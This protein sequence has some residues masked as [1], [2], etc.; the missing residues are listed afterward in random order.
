MSADPLG[1]RSRPV[2]HPDETS[3]PT[4][5]TEPF[6][7]SA[8]GSVQ[9]KRGNL[10]GGAATEEALASSRKVLFAHRGSKDA[11]VGLQQWFAPP[12]AAA[13]IAAVFEHG[14]PPSAVFDPTAGSGSL[15]SGFP[16]ESR[17]GV[18]IDSDHATNAPYQ[19]ITA[20]AQKVVP[21]MRA[22]GLR[23]PAIALNPPFGLCW[24][25]AAHA[26]GEINSTVLAF[27]WAV[28]L[29]D[30][31]G[32]GAMICGTDRLATSVLGRPEA[33]GVYAVL[34]VEGPLFDGVDLATS[35]AF[36]VSP[37]NLRNRSTDHES[38]GP[39]RLKARRAD[40][41]EMA[42]AVAETRE[43]RC[44]FISSYSRIQAIAAGFS[45]VSSE[46]ARRQGEGREKGRSRFDLLLKGSKVSVNLRAFATLALREAGVLREV[47]LLNNQHS[48]YFGQNKRAW[49]TLVNAGEAGHITIDPAL[50]ERAEAAVAQAELQSIPLFPVKPQMRLGWL[51][52]LDKIRCKTD[53]PERGYTADEDYPLSTSSKVASET[54]RR[55]VENK[56]GDAEL[57]R[58]TTERK[59]LEVRIGE[60][61]FDEG[62][63]NIAYIAEHFELPDP[64]CVATHPDTDGEVLHHREL[65]EEIAAENG[66][67]LK[68]F[69]TDH[70]SR[71]LVKG[72]GMLAMEQGLGKTL[73]QMC[74]AE[75]QIRLGAKPQVLFVVPQDLIPQWQREARKFFGRELEEIRTPV[76][77]REAAR[78]IRAGESGWW[79]TYYEALSVVGR[80]KEVLPER[81]LDHRTALAE[82]LVER[83]KEKGLPAEV[84]WNLTEGRGTATTKDVCPECGAD[85]AYG[86]DTE[87]CRQCGYAHRSLHVKSAASH[88]SGAFEHG[89]V[90]VDEVS[91][92][93]GDD[94]LRSKAVRAL[95]RGP[96]RYGA[97]GTPVSN[98]ISDSFWGLLFCLGAASPAFPYSFE[99]KPKFET[100]F[101]VVEYLHGRA[102]DNEEH[103]KK[104]KKV[105]P[106]ITN[107]SQFWRLAQPGVSRCRKEQTGEPLAERTYHPVRAPMGA[108]QKKAHDFWLKN[109]ESYFAWRHPDHQLVKEGLVEK[110][111]AA[112]GQLW[113]LETAAPLP[114][115]DEPSREWPQARAKL[116][117]LSNFTPA[118]LKVLEL[119]MEH[120]E[121]GEKVLIGSDLIMTGRWLSD[122]LR[123]KGVRAVNITEERSGKVGTKNP[124][125]RSREVE[126]FV[127]GDAQVLCAGVGAMKLGHN[128]DVASTVI[129]SGLPYSFMALDQFLARVHRL[130]SRRAVSVYVVIPRGSL[131]ERKWQLLSDKGAASDLAFDGELTVAP[132]KPVDWAKVLEEMKQRGIR[133]SGDEDLVL[134]ADVKEAWS[135]VPVLRKPAA[136]SSFPDAAPHT[137]NNGAGEPQSLFDFLSAASDA[138]QDGPAKQLALFE[139]AEV[140]EENDR[141]AA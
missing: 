88:L 127:S 132:E 101:C 57:R 37:R 97:T 36:F 96:H 66:F 111:A 11:L 23:F 119:A 52:D 93:R 13:L 65:L 110:F 86:W 133:G 1:D 16:E 118:N 67:E 8:N 104:R 140:S 136:F 83:K 46:H 41:P 114:A 62:E 95:A 12:E 87:V 139:L 68:P 15:L 25:D 84:P 4:E 61:S 31:F 122:R 92:I 44:G 116:G 56:N 27:L 82:R 102:S 135:S 78:R 58:F 71:L 64:G 47:Q 108:S 109:F 72:R 32:Q 121:K 19:A 49:H 105:L 45:A 34:D 128:L 85:T 75:A 63:E 6:A 50:G 113:R 42:E 69:Q 21:L 117:E 24:R 90:C 40:L 59:L 124:R 130:T 28:D 94:S 70:L 141:G 79:I 89:V 74:L 138:I 55:V 20:D 7:N 29:L 77:A 2:H 48:P 107:V 14:G 39:P 80:K 38:A 137:P 125:K 73:M 33:G 120:A 81:F 134:E 53:D 76:Q 100:D 30:S 103:L 99:G 35:I 126:Q 91:E 3:E 22:A 51:T 9:Q 5:P 43:E 10:F 26:K 98:F 131:A 18:E 115:S 17:F 54:R 60:Y 129:V 106:Q 112:L 123:E